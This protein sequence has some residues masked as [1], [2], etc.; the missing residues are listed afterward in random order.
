MCR[1][2]PDSE[3]HLTGWEGGRGGSCEI[4]YREFTFE[5]GPERMSGSPVLTREAMECPRKDTKPLIEHL[6]YALIL[7]WYLKPMPS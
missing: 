6:L 7:L 2:L 3:L 5:L 4:I 1:E